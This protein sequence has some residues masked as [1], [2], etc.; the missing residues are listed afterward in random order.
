MANEV[1]D[2]SSVEDT[3][4]TTDTEETAQA[5]EYLPGE[6]GPSIVTR[7]KV[8]KPED[9]SNEGM[10]GAV[11]ALLQ[12]CAEADEAQHR[13]QFLQTVEQQL[14]DRGYQHLEGKGEGWVIGSATFGGEGHNG[15]ADMD[16]A[17][18]MATNVFSSQGDITSSALC[19]GKIEVSF[20]PKHSK[21]PGDVAASE[22]ANEYRWLWEK[23]NPDLQRDIMQNGWTDCRVAVWTRTIADR[24][25]GENEDGSPCQAEISSAYGVLETKF[26]MLQEK[27]EK[28][29]YAQ[30]FEET[31]YALA[32]SVYPWMGDKIKP[33]GGAWGAQEFERICRINVRSG[34]VGR[35]I[36]GSTGMRE[37]TL[38][39][40]WV[41]PGMFDDDK[42]NAAQREFLLESFPTGLFIIT[43]GPNELVCC[44]DE[45]MDDHLALGFYT[46]GKGQNRRALCTSDLPLQKRINK[47]ADLWDEFIRGAIPV[48]LLDNDLV[49][50]E[51][52]SEL[53]ASPRR[54]LEVAVPL[55]KDITQLVGQTPAARP[56]DGMMQMFQYYVGPLLQ[57]IDGAT[58]A[59]EGTGEGEDNTV[60]ATLIRLNQSLER[61]G[62]PWQMANEVI[63][64]SAYLAARCCGFNT[65]DELMDNVP[66]RGDVAVDPALLRGGR[67]N[68][69]PET[70]GF[71][72]ESAAQREAK[73]RDLMEMA[74]QN[75]DVAEVVARTSNAREIVS[76]LHVDDVIT[77]DEAD[78]EDKQLEEIE[79]L[80]HTEPLINPE[81][82]TLQNEVESLGAIHE[83]GKAVAAQMLQAGNVPDQNTIQQGAQLEQQ[84]QQ[85]QQQLQNTPQYLPSVPVAQDESEDHATEAATVFSWMQKSEG[86]AIRRKAAK[87]QPGGD[88]NTSPN[89]CMWTNVYLHWQGH[90]AMSKQFSK[91]KP[92]AKISFTGK[93]SPEQQAQLL[94]AAAGIQTSPQ[95]A[96][97]PNE[98]ETETIQRTA[99]A[100]VKT[101]T[102]R[103]L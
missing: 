72:P 11:I 85:L 37:T 91:N 83:T 5:E 9:L 90:M 33:G 21:R 77:F 53:E 68:Y 27:L 59:L 25:F 50:A 29:G 56:I 8:W 1:L 15:L 32:R 20:I 64:R 24:R 67:F 2:E 92:Q 100:E 78:S 49:S 102:R 22:A 101:R 66:G 61:F 30:I 6:L 19:R 98:Q 55:G 93:L 26:P 28:C 60:G 4:D 103:R 39:Y 14:Y 16:D 10:K 31:D 73:V 97:A 65:D 44:W 41:R 3:T 89:W 58:P 84:V 34:V 13:F 17:S 99:D 38:G 95:A 94:L 51:A 62:I 63:A 76:A 71:I 80:L 69:K 82:Q 87:E 57:Q 42:I 81:W 45:S 12:I 70:A 86:R 54:F 88:L 35:V 46:R 96:N 23:N 74:A 40:T 47:W 7:S 43:S 52:V 18:V 75:P 79:V 48:T 36:T